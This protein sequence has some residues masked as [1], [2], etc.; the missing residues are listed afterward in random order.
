M[1]HVYESNPTS[2]LTSSLAVIDREVGYIFGNEKSFLNRFSKSDCMDLT[3]VSFTGHDLKI[4]YI[5][6]NGQHVCDRV[7]LKDYFEWRCEVLTK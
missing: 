4:S 5:L 1:Q 3:E 6:Y 2:D 7:L